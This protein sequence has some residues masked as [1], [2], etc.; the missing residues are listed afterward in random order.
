LQVKQ[1][2]GK[3]RVSV[4]SKNNVNLN[5]PDPLTATNQISIKKVMFFNQGQVSQNNS[6]TTSMIITD[7]SFE[8]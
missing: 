6:Q 5:E 1:T 2:P 4:K 8:D 7:K 3:S